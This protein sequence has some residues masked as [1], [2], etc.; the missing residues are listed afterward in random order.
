MNKDFSEAVISEQANVMAPCSFRG[1]IGSKD[2]PSGL[3]AGA[4]A[5]VP[6]QQAWSAPAQYK[7]V[8]T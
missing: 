5:S 7:E 1:R 4:L 3:V 6:G 8:P 2:K